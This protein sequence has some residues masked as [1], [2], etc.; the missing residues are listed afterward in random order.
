MKFPLFLS[1]AALALLTP[2]TA[3]A[4]EDSLIPNGDFEEGS[5]GWPNSDGISYEKDGD[6]TFMRLASP[7]VG[8]QVQAHRKIALTGADKALTL[9]FRARWENIVAGKEVWHVGSFVVHFKDDA[10]AILKPDPK[11]RHFK[12]DSGEWKE[13]TMEL[14]VPE[15]AAVI[16]I[17]PALFQVESGTLDLDDLVLKPAAK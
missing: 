4:E 6:N 11:P 14:E 1:L 3:L 16:E 17:M 5:K 13:F 8:K 7:E 2:F 12:G 15:N 9:T 10:G